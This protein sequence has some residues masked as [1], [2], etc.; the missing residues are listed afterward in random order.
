MPLFNLFKNCNYYWG[1]GAYV[2]YFVNH[3][4]YTEPPHCIALPLFAIALICQLSNFWCALQQH[5]PGKNKIA[6]AYA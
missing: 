1:F 6:A 2:S 5:Q 4:L 3:P